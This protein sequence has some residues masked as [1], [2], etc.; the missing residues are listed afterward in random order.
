MVR[1]AKDHPWLRTFY[2]TN[3]LSALSLKHC[4]QRFFFTDGI[5]VRVETVASAVGR[6]QLRMTNGSRHET[7]FNSENER[8]NRTP[9]GERVFSFSFSGGLASFARSLVR[10]GK[11]VGWTLRFPRLT[12][13]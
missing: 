12:H 4:W 8:A 11:G 6:R 13:S 1:L 3:L 9:S 10:G 5:V 7:S 2:V